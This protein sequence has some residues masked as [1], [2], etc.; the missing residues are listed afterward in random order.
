MQMNKELLS[1]FNL[2]RHPFSKEIQDKELVEFESFKQT[3]DNVR[4]LIE[5]KG[6]GVLTGKSGSGKSCIIRKVISELNPGLY[7][8][9][10]LCHT[11]VSLI[12]FYFHIAGT[13]GIEPTARK[14]KMFKAIKDRIEQLNTSNR[15]HPV[16]F[17][18]EA[19]YTNFF[20][21][22]T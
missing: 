18:D 19:H 5:M 3:I 21:F 17:V 4:L 14:A 6:I 7:K 15:I 2:H 10:Y 8:P 20:S 13:L 22:Q 12:E 11:S 16:L 9:I 1:Y